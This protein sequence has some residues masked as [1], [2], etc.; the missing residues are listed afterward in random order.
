[1]WSRSVLP[2]KPTQTQKRKVGPK[3]IL[4]GV[5]VEVPDKSA[6]Y[7]PSFSHSWK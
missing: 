7:V 6:E 2:L 3:E 1:M 5:D 4:K